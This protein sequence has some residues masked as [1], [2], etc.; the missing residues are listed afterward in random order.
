VGFEFEF[1][2]RNDTSMSPDGDM[3]FLMYENGTVVSQ[4][5]IIKHVNKI[6]G[7]S[8]KT[9]SSEAAAIAL[10]QKSIQPTLVRILWL[11]L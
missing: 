11:Y 9:S 3:P 4:R 2:E 6:L 8:E 10:V 7:L 1:E 5:D